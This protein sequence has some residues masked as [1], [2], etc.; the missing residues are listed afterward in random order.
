V[1]KQAQDFLAAAIGHPGESLGTLLGNMIHRRIQNAEGIL[2]RAHFTLLNIGVTPK[3]IPLKIIQPL[4]EAAS[5]EEEPELQQLWV[6]L[7]ANSADPRQENTV[8][9]SFILMAKELTAREATFL[10]KL[11][12]LQL[13]GIMPHLK[14]GDFTDFDLKQAY[15]DA[16]LSRQSRIGAL[17]YGDFQK[18]GDDLKADLKEF[19]VSLDLIKRLGIIVEDVTNEAIDLEKIASQI[20][21]KTLRSKLDVDAKTSYTFSALGRMFMSACQKPPNAS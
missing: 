18:H 15:A 10:D 1:A 19:A 8:Y 6:N 17:T 5:L 13:E 11:H 21:H 4:L 16:G 9:P 3:E 2:S 14:A 7:L 20:K 12:S